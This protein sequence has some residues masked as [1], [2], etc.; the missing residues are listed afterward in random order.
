MS[1][2]YPPPKFTLGDLHS[3]IGSVLLAFAKPRFVH[4]TA[5][6]SID[7]ESRVGAVHQSRWRL[8]LHIVILGFCV[9]SRSWKPISQSSWGTVRGFMFPPEAVWKS[10]ETEHRLFNT[11]RF[12]FASWPGLPLCDWTVVAP[13]C[14]YSTYPGQII[15]GCN[16]PTWLEAKDGLLWQCHI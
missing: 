11:Q 9:A 6:C 4:Q 12:C 1:K 8:A 15:Q 2:M 7:P 16:F 14:P 13:R 10:S 3:S 5:R